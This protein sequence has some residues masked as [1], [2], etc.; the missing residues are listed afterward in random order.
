MSQHQGG[1]G[2]DVGG[3][4]RATAV[5]PGPGPGGPHQGEVRPQAFVD[6][7]VYPGQHL[8]VD[9][10]DQFGQTNANLAGV[11][12]SL[13]DPVIGIG[14]NYHRVTQLYNIS[15]TFSISY[16]LIQSD[17]NAI[18]ND[19]TGSI[20]YGPNILTDNPLFVDDDG[21]D[22]TVGTLD[23]DLRL[24]DGS[25]AIDAGNN[26]AIALTTDL[27]GNARFYDDI[28]VTDTGNGVSPLVD[29]GAY[30][31]QTNSPL[32]LYFPVVVKDD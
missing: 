5:E 3:G 26:E 7:A 12:L 29:M 24:S 30:E 17:T 19:A 22:D 4:D 13:F 15:A 28:N 32:V 27:D 14:G 25:P 21:A 11:T 6:V 10:D 18:A 8:S 23:D 9:I 16:S 31:K 2:L 1:D 20:V